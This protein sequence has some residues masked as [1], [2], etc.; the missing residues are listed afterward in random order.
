MMT[1]RDCDNALLTQVRNAAQTVLSMSETFTFS[2]LEKCLPAEALQKVQKVILT[3]CGDSYCIGVAAR[4][5][6]E[7]EGAYPG[8]QAEALR[9]IEAAR[10]YR[11][12]VGWG[13]KKA[14]DHLIC[15]VSITG[16]PVRPREALARI[17]QLG[18]ISVAFTDNENSLFAREAKY[19]VRIN[20]PQDHYKPGVTDEECPGMTSYIAGCYAVM[21]FGLYMCVCKG[22]MTKQQAE[23]QRQAAIEYA[24]A[25]T[26]EVIDDLEEK[27]FRFAEKLQA[28]GFDCMDFIAEDQE[29]ATAF[30]A[31]AKMVESFGAV[32]THDDAEDWCHINYFNRNPARIATFLMANPSSP[33]FSRDQ[34][35]AT[36]AVAIKRPLAIICEDTADGLPEQA[37]TFKMPTPKYRWINALLQHIPM[38][39][40]AA[41]LGIFRRQM[42]VG[43]SSELHE[44]DAACARF[45]KSEQVFVEEL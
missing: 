24:R 9:N 18:G 10:Y 19:A 8:F 14:E 22:L 42:P 31:S 4:P 15:A 33:S 32:T 26:P 12:Y 16:S 6:F 20:V 38:D 39:F 25:F 17:N 45:K 30:F 41:Y 36:C 35:T 29:F 2:Y 1:H 7:S 11:T 5:C 23:E 44:R 27:A 43:I 40:I 13:E 28:D 37:W 34:E 3:G 21:M